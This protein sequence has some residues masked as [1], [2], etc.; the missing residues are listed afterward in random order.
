MTDSNNTKEN[1][2]TSSQFYDLIVGEEFSWQVIIYDLVKTEQLDPWDIDLVVLAQKYHQVIEQMEEAD[3]NVSS[4]VLL[5]CALLLRLKSEVLLN[6]YIP[7]L[8]ELLYGKQENKKYEMERI[9][10]DENELPTLVPRT[11]MPRHRKVTLNE[12]IGALNKAI[13]TENRRIRREIRQ[14]RAEKSALV[15]M[16]NGNKMPLKS[17]IKI[18]FQKIRAFLNEP[19]RVKMKYHELAPTREEKIDSFVPVL[20]LSNDEKLYL[21]Q[22]QHFGDIHLMLDKQ[23]LIDIPGVNDN[24]ERDDIVDNI[25]EFK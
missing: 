23:H 17:M 25:K 10:I 8:D 19:E 4:K 18:I 16:P 3:F 20:H 1:R 5:A 24:L 6:K 21:E 9:F 13:E 15:V 11:P 7:N 14:K 22:P 2:I 12:L